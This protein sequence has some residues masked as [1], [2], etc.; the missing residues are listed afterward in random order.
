MMERRPL[1][2]VRR[3]D[4][5][6]NTTQNT[7]PNTTQTPQ[8]IAHDTAPQP[9]QP[10]QTSQSSRE[11]REEADVGQT[12]QADDSHVHEI[13]F[14]GACRRLDSRG[15]RSSCA[16]FHASYKSKF[17]TAVL[18]DVD[19]SLQA[20]L[21]GAV[22]ALETVKKIVTPEVQHKIKK[23]R[24]L[25]VED[26]NFIIRGDSS[27]IANAI[28]SGDILRYE[29][30][31]AV[32]PADH[33]WSK[34]KTLL[35]ELQHRGCVIDWRWTPRL[36]NREADELCNAILD[37]RTPD[38]SVRSPVTPPPFRY[39]DLGEILELLQKQ[40][41]AT[42]K[43]LPN[44]LQP[45][46]AAYLFS[47]VTDYDTDP[48]RTRLIFLIS[49]HLVSV[50]M[51][52]FVQGKA[53]FR[54]YRMHLLML[55]DK[56][57]LHQTLSSLLQDLRSPSPEQRKPNTR[58]APTS[59]QVQAMC[60]MGTHA[61][62]HRETNVGIATFSQEITDK[63]AA[64]FPKR[65]TPS[66]LQR[67]EGEV[68][69]ISFA[70]IKL[71]WR[72]LRI[73]KAPGLSGWTKELL[74]PLIAN[75]PPS[76]QASLAKLFTDLVNASTSPL[77]KRFLTHMILVP[78]VYTDRPGK[79]RPILI[80][81]IITRLCW[82]IALSGINDP[83]LEA[84]T[85]VFGKDG[86]TTLAVVAAQAALSNDEVLVSCDAVNAFP[87]LQRETFMHYIGNHPIYKKCLGM[88]NLMYARE[89]TA[90][91]YHMDS[92]LPPQTFSI[93]EGAIQGCVSGPLMYALGTLQTI[94]TFGKNLIVCADDVLIRGPDSLEIAPKVFQAFEEIGQR[95]N[96]PKLSIFHSATTRLPKVHQALAH[97]SIRT[98]IIQYLG[99]II[100]PNTSSAQTREALA[101][102]MSGHIMKF[103]NKLAATL[104]LDAPKQCK[105]II[106]RSLARSLIYR[107]QTC[108]HPASALIFREIDHHTL[109][110]LK[111]LLPS[112]DIPTHAGRIQLPTEDG[113]LGIFKYEAIHPWLQHDTVLRAK[114]FLRMLALELDVQA[115]HQTTLLAAW[116]TNT[117]L[118]NGGRKERDGRS[119]DKGQFSS[120]LDARP[121]SQ[122]TRVSD[123]T[124]HN[125]IDIIL[126]NLQPIRGE[127]IQTEPPNIQLSSLTREEFTQHVLTCARCG[128]GGHY[129]RHQAVLHAVRNTCRFHGIHSSVPKHTDMPLPDRSKGG[130]DLIVFGKEMDAVD[131]SICYTYTPVYGENIRAR[132]SDTF[133]EKERQYRLF[134]QTAQCRIIPFVV[135]VY[136]LIARET[137]ELIRPWLEAT[138]DSRLLLDIYHNV[139]FSLIKALHQNYQY[140]QSKYALQRE[141]DKWTH[142]T[143]QELVT[144]DKSQPA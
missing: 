80:T 60:A 124:F 140:I 46:W 138:P 130:P 131:F 43:T 45:L 65:Q 102:A 73:A 38:E 24:R 18:L 89:N 17:T 29:V 52:P 53:D 104:D 15:C 1:Q 135:S 118:S 122:W 99:G 121:T 128:Q 111:S 61:K 77:E 127:C 40:R 50:G 56:N 39:D 63:I 112:I 8:H 67:T 68:E 66:P 129:A 35:T 123:E 28:R 141:H 21:S 137:R 75:P 30:K 133:R 71:A 72:K 42:L 125:Q 96:G 74:A 115:P 16:V 132:M 84:S 7:A 64:S 82:H 100:T 106:I 101:I 92:T 116:K 22:L 88:V 107:A 90:T 87:T 139:Q 47:L 48:L 97:A 143:T 49:P 85:Q 93:T 10:Q 114:K 119:F 62:L 23:G 6:E 26:C 103:K 110:A 105:F 78:F 57:Y 3:E 2:T 20:E 4:E 33:L 126:Q 55:Q 69:V 86:Q 44:Q 25:E 94:R 14:D 142:Q 9:P 136:G 120:W 95:I 36:R 134:K 41:R 34:L 76:I 144:E 13:H 51:F 91:W 81:D 79:V 31:R 11:S 59:R 5:T 54:A 27:V 19:D 12:A 109:S 108:F 32:L 70:D 58:G 117:Y 98:D 37:G 83:T 113:G